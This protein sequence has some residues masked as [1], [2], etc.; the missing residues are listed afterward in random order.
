M[1]L[2]ANPFELGVEGPPLKLTRQIWKIGRDMP[3][4]LSQRRYS[5]E[6]QL[7]ARVP[8]LWLP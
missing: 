2:V 3:H 4:I 5:K 7:P 1:P 8:A 6:A